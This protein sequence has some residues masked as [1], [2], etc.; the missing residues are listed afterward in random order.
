[1]I[2]ESA[3][4]TYPD[5]ELKAYKDRPGT[6]EFVTRR[7]FFPEASTAFETRYFEVSAGGYTSFEMHAHEHCVVVL[8]G[9]GRVRLGDEWQH[10]SLGDTI[11]VKPMTP[12]QFEN[13]AEEPF[14]FLCMVDKDR[15]RPVLLDPDGSPRPSNP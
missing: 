3:D 1:M 8:R 10:I 5:V 7:E 14:G 2:R 4:F 11:H 13:T 15:D 12:H 6:F 9:Q